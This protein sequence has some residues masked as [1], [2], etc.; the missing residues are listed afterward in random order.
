MRNLSPFVSLSAVLLFSG[1]VVPAL[2]AFIPT[3]PPP[4]STTTT[5]VNPSN[6]GGGG[7]HLD[8]N[9]AKDARE[10]P[11]A[12]IGCM[13]NSKAPD[14]WFRNIGNTPIAAGR[15]ITW[16]VAGT[17]ERGTFTLPKEI[18]PGDYL[19]DSAALKAALG[20]DTGCMAKLLN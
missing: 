7:E 20:K 2:A 17:G 19:P 14:L 8:L 15:V 9:L 5:T 13:G 3:P 12:L 18:K 16:Q 10:N 4:P 1:V 6:G 11:T